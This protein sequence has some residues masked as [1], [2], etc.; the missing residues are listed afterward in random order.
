MWAGSGR[1]ECL[2]EDWRSRRLKPGRWVGVS[3]GASGTGGVLSPY[4]AGEDVF[5]GRLMNNGI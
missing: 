2:G 3:G 5:S 1:E 4:L